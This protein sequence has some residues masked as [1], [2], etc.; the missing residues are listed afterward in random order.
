LHAS[1]VGVHRACGG[2]VLMPAAAVTEQAE[3]TA[4]CAAAAGVTLLPLGRR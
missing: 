1:W 3:V 2:S 4:A